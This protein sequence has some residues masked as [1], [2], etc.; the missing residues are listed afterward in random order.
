MCWKVVVW[1]AVLMFALGAQ[2][3]TP[4]DPDTAR[5][6]P[7]LI[8]PE[9]TGS[10][11]DRT[12]RCTLL[13]EF[14]RRGLVLASYTGALVVTEMRRRFGTTVELNGQI[15]LPKPALDYLLREFPD[16]A[17]LVNHFK[18]THYNI[19]FT[20]PERSQFFATNGRS[21]EAMFNY[22]DQSLGFD[23]SNYLM[24]ESGRA[25]VFL[26]HFSGNGIIELA[27]RRTETGSAYTAYVHIFTDSRAFH[28]FFESALFTHLVGSLLDRILG[29]VVSAV[30]QFTE[31]AEDFSAAHAEFSAGLAEQLR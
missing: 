29:D 8:T 20:N 25:K 16:T 4:T 31:A 14:S 3:D 21:M 19:F 28:A 11:E 17:K 12:Q 1:S 18:Q 5:N 7:Q 2:A 10:L 9:F 15:P 22:I 26:W 13:R 30:Q 23:E 6:C 24:S 27:L